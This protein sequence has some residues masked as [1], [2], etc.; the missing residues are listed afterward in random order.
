MAR[1]STAANR[2][3]SV[4]IDEDLL[5]AARAALGT[6]TVRDTIESAL[7]EVVAARSRRDEVAALGAMRGMDLD[8]DRVMKGTWRD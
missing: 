6:A 5:A 3:T 2:K 4:V 1:G 8:D 7:R